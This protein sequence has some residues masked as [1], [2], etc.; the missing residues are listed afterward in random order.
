MDS[1][2]ILTA[3]SSSLNPVTERTGRELSYVIY[4]DVYFRQLILAG[5]FAPG[6]GAA[7]DPVPHTAAAARDPYSLCDRAQACVFH[8]WVRLL[9]APPHVCQRAAAHA[10]MADAKTWSLGR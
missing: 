3:S 9:A 6:S 7:Q 5:R 8:R 1:L 4:G 10:A 2:A